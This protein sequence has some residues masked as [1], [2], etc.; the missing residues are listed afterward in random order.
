LFMFKQIKEAV[1]I[2]RTFGWRVLVVKLLRRLKRQLSGFS[3]N[4]Y[5]L[6]IKTHEPGTNGLQKQKQISN[7]FKYHPKISLITPVWNTNPDWLTATID[8]VI[9]QTYDNWELC[10][11]DGASSKEN[12]RIILDEYSRKDSRI[13]VKYLPQNK[14]ISG[15]TNEALSLATGEYIG[16]LDHDDELAPFAL[17]EVVKALNEKPETDFIYSDEDK[18]DRKGRRIEPVFKPDWSPDLFLSCMYTCHLGIYRKS[19]TDAIAGFRPEYDGSQDY[20]FGL[21][22][23]EKT[24]NIYH[25]PL[26]LYHWRMADG[27]AAGDE[28]A[29]MYAYTAA[30]KALH[31]YLARNHIQGDVVDGTWLGS[32]RVRREIVGN[33]LV[34]I[35]IP[36]KENVDIL[37]NCITSIITRTSYTNYEILV[38]DN[39]SYDEA[40]LEY[41][42]EIEKDSRIKVLHY[43]SSFNFSAINNYAVSQAGGEYNLF[44]NNDTRIITTEWISCMLEH[45]QREDVGAVGA[46]LLFPNNSIQHCGVI[47]GLGPVEGEEVAGHPYS[48]MFESHGHGGR[49]SVIGNYSAVTAACMMIRKQ[50]FLEMG[51]FDEELAYAYNDIDLCLRLR[52]RG[53]LIVYTPYASL[54]HYES[55]SR[56]SE[57]TQEKL[58]R[59]KKEVTRMR[60]KWG[61][62][63]SRGD[64]YYN[65]NL[66]LTR[67]DY[68]L[69]L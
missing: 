44:L 48:K 2:T 21:R 40:T 66:S 25:I 52:K 67:S 15:N 8:S 55:L 47:L 31:E 38:T 30:K 43:D 58:A 20:D 54:Y 57:D 56:G 10:I 9:N 14:G 69:R 12:V 19:I 46:K 26:I 33:P 59:H 63:I 50:V 36:S 64:P 17:Y 62:I 6:W 7:T 22:F 23:I 28:K 16:L 41:Y 61:N 45:S 32:Y 27:S 35:I 4:S 3:S 5:A 1:L 60:N 29:K 49:I 24:G 42:R 18:I 34:S 13:K 51:G 11:A 53:Y 39:Q 68:S 65:P 37:K